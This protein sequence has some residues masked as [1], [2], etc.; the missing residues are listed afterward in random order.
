MQFNGT[1]HQPWAII[2][3]EQVATHAPS[4]TLWTQTISAVASSTRRRMTGPLFTRRSVLML[5]NLSSTKFWRMFWA[6]SQISSM[7]LIKMP[8]SRKWHGGTV[9]KQKIHCKGH[10]VLH[11]CRNLVNSPGSKTSNCSKCWIAR[12]KA[13]LDSAN[14]V[15]SCIWSLLSKLSNYYNVY[16][17]MAYFFSIYLAVDNTLYLVNVRR[18]LLDRSASAKKWSMRLLMKSVALAQRV[19]WASMTFK[20]CILKSFRVY[21][22]NLYQAKLAISRTLTK[23]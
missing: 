23:T 20:C 3:L 6:L 7:N 9:G 17:I 5:T 8:A 13:L 14:F 4:V 1:K 10:S 18:S 15:R 21:S 22:P 2:S 12:V 19:W 16:T 11:N